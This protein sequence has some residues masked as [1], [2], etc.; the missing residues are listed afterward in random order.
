MSTG[1]VDIGYETDDSAAKIGGS[2]PPA[3]RADRAGVT[4]A[5]AQA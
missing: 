1:T 4:E 5:T 2:A 3:G